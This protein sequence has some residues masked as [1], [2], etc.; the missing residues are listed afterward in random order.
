MCAWI[1]IPSI[2]LAGHSTAL[3]T[4]RTLGFWF[5]CSYNSGMFSWEAVRKGT[6]FLDLSPFSCQHLLPPLLLYSLSSLA[7]NPCQGSQLEALVEQQ[8]L[9]SQVSLATSS[10]VETQLCPISSHKWTEMCVW[11]GVGEPGP[12]TPAETF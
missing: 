4:L 10:L 3:G 11:W 6:D 1:V 5:R 7:S 9:A 12:R 2:V 8:S